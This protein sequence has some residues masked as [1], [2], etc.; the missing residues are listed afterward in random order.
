MPWVAFVEFF[1]FFFFWL[2][3]YN[4]SILDL[5][6]IYIGIIGHDLSSQRFSPEVDEAGAVV[7]WGHGGSKLSPGSSRYLFSVF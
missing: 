1:F 7:T 4:G 2:F 3:G 5:Y 6:W